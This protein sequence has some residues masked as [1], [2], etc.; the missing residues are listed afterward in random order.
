MQLPKPNTVTKNE[1][2]EPSTYLGKQIKILLTGLN[3]HHAMSW[4]FLYPTEQQ[5]QLG[6]VGITTNRIQTSAPLS[7]KGS[8]KRQ[9]QEQLLLQPLCLYRG[10]VIPETL[11]N[12]TQVII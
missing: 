3:Y 4:V 5:L 6:I 1:P 10:K 11:T 2:V 7:I 12:Y 8:S 9:S